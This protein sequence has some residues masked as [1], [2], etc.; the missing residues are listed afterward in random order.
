VDN[1]YAQ[2][3]FLPLA[4]IA[5]VFGLP[6]GAFVIFRVL[7]HRERMAMIAAGLPPDIGTRRSLSYDERDHT[8]ESARITL[9]KGIRLALIGFALTLGI[10]IA[11]VHVSSDGFSWHPGPWLLIGLLPMFIGIAQVLIGI[12]SGARVDALTRRSD[13]T[14]Y[15]PQMPPQG[16]GSQRAMPEP[17]EFQPPSD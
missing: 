7:A 1:D 8:P 17:F 5:I 16:P 14:L 11:T 3:V 4:S 2:S 15:A 6:I 10:T 9:N 13:T 12:L